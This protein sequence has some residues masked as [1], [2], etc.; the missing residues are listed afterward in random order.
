MEQWCVRGFVGFCDSEE[1]VI[2]DLKVSWQIPAHLLWL[3]IPKDPLGYRYLWQHWGVGVGKGIFICIFV[4]FSF[5]FCRKE[6]CYWFVSLFRLVFFEPNSEKGWKCPPLP[7]PRQD[8]RGQT[9]IC[10]FCPIWELSELLFLGKW[11]R[12]RFW[13]T[14]VQGG[15]VGGCKSTGNEFWI[16]QLMQ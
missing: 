10:R 4:L 3:I 15:E 11:G 12:G 14:V 7:E 16:S 9:S 1:I 8:R 5:I 2:G 13:S 6:P